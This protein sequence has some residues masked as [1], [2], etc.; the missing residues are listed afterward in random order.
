MT[1]YR[2]R[3]LAGNAGLRCREL[4]REGSR[5]QEMVN[6]I[7]QDDVHILIGIPRPKMVASTILPVFA[8]GTC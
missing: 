7:N 6:S 5:S 3:V 8:A 4:L 2:Y 1:K